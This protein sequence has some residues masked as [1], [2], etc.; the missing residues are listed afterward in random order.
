MLIQY[1]ATRGDAP[2]NPT[3]Y[4]LRTSI[5]LLLGLLVMGLMLSFDYRRLKVATPFIYVAF[6]VFLLVVLFFER[7]MGSSRWITL[8]PIDFQPSEYCK[9]VL[10][11]AL[12]NF[13]SDNKA[14][15]DSLRSFMVPVTWAVPFMLLVF[16]QPDLGTTLVL[17]AILLGMLFLVGCRMRYWVSFVALGVI[18]FTLGFVLHIFKPY[19][20]ERFMAFLKQGANIQQAGYH[21]L[22]SKIA[23]G[24]GGFAGK[25]YLHGTQ[26]KLDYVPEQ[27]T[28]FIFCT[29]G[30]EWGFLGTMVVVL[31]FAGLLV[32]LLFLAERQRSVFARLYGYGV[33]SIL[34]F[35]VAVNIAMT[36]GLFPVIGIPLPFFSY[37][38]SS[39]LAF[40]MLLFIFVRLDAVRKIYLI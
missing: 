28:D 32:R 26:T 34:F 29:V 39:M 8:G 36:I 16:L 18:G 27:S 23:I 7:V 38:G 31:A 3:Y 15:P 1:S 14:E 22:Q 40:S 5:S 10:I 19:Q 13:F 30:E 6:L 21:L 25:G 33:I 37:G 11:L 17:A 20:V 2:G 9:L 35:H 12:A 24:A 4:V